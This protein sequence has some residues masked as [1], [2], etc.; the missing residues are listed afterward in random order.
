MGAGLL[1][2][3]AHSAYGNVGRLARQHQLPAYGR[4]CVCGLPARLAGARPDPY[5]PHGRDGRPVPHAAR[6]FRRQSRFRRGHTTPD[7]SRQLQPGGQRPHPGPG[8][9]L[10]GH[11]GLH[12]RTGHALLHLGEYR[13]AP[14]REWSAG[15]FRMPG[16]GRHSLRSLHADHAG[17]RQPDHHRLQRGFHSGCAGAQRR[18]A[19][20]WVL[21][22]RHA[23]RGGGWRQPVHHCGLVGGQDR[24]LPDRHRLP[25]RRRGDLPLHKIVRPRRRRQRGGHRGRHRGHHRR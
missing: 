1:P 24:R 10:H 21:L 22:Q 19:G 6:R 25:G 14:D 4:H 8:R 23:E 17:F 7:R 15:R 9:T 18:R 3:R 13:P 5:G 2:S 20:A 16:A 12:R 11:H